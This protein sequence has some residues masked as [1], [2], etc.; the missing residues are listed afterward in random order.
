MHTA[1]RAGLAILNSTVQ[2]EKFMSYFPFA[3]K[4]SALITLTT[5]W[6]KLYG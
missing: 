5:I 4:M 1:K 6:W 3:K 2:I